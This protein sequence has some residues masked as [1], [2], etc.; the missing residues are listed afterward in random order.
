MSQQV[1]KGTEVFVGYWAKDILDQSQ[2][3]LTI[4]DFTVTL[5][6]DSNG[7]FGTASE[8]VTL[9]EL[10][11]TNLAGQYEFRFTPDTVATYALEVT[12]GF[13]DAQGGT[14]RT[15]VD[16]ASAVSVTGS[17]L[18]TLAQVKAYIGGYGN[19]TEDDSVIE[20]IIDRATSYITNAT[21]RTHTSANHTEKYDGGWYKSLVLQHQPVQSVSSVHES[22]DIPRVYDSSTL[23]D[24]DDE[25]ILDE[26]GML[27]RVGSQWASGPNAIQVVYTAG[28]AT[29]PGDLNWAA[30]RLSALWLK[31]RDFLGITSQSLGD[32]SV[33]HFG[34]QDVPWD[35]QQVIDR[36]TV[37]GGCV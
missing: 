20:D 2:T 33:T 31:S 10:D 19:D 4:S 36:Y 30:V 22:T 15:L 25:Y 18:C 5:K 28:A 8:P 37:A 13:T 24:A 7:T 3:G 17:D 1:A 29:V 27:W 23:L 34:P 6:E 9:A 32:G 35:V 26:S 12:P 21:G 16:V 11:A 14:F